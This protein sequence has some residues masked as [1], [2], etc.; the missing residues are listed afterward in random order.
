MKF[1]QQCRLNVLCADDC[2][3][4]DKFLKQTVVIERLG[5]VPVPLAQLPPIKYIVIDVECFEIFCARACALPR[6]L[7]ILPMYEVGDFTLR[8]I[9][10]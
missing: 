7:H 3:P 4:T 6:S 8:S 10:R 5:N 9:M 2:I 1:I